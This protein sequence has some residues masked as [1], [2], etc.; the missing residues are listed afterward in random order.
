M[1][2]PHMLAPP[3]EAARFP[4][5]SAAIFT[6]GCVRRKAV[7]AARRSMANG[8]V[9]SIFGAGTIRRQTLPM[10]QENRCGNAVP[11]NAS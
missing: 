4:A 5:V 3:A 2:L 11:N 6:I 7:V 1:S 10:R 9:T 8:D